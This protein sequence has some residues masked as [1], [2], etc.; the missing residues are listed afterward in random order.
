MA[1]ITD[2]PIAYYCAM[3]SVQLLQDEHDE[4]G[5]TVWAWLM[6]A[7]KSLGL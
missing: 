5:A 1:K 4:R 2:N 3:R 7:A 6:T